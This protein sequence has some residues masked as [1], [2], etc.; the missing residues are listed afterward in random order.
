M[1]D[2]DLTAAREAVK[3]LRRVS[4]PNG[5]V[6]TELVQIVAQRFG[7]TERTVW[8]WLRNGVPQPRTCEKPGTH[9]QIAVAKENGNRKRAWQELRAE[10]AY[11]NGYRQFLRD[12]EMLSPVTHASIIG[13]VKAGITQGLYTKAHSEQRLDRVIFD[14]TEADI[15]LRRVYAGAEEMFRPWVTL[16]VDSATRMILAVVVT[17]GDGVRGDPPTESIVALMASAIRGSTAADGTF[18]GGVPRLVQ[19]DNAKAHLAEAMLN[20]YLEL[21]IAAHAIRPGSPWEDGKV[22][23]LMRTFKDEFLSALPGYTKALTDRYEREPWTPE[24][25]MP[26]EEFNERL[27]EW[28]DH[29]NF[30]RVHSALGTTPFE[31]WRDDTGEIQVV[32]PAMLRHGFLAETR[33]RKVSKNGLRF[34]NIDYTHPKLATYVGRKVELR[35]LPNDTTFI[36]VFIDGQHVCTAVPHA[37]LDMEQRRQIVRNRTNELKNVDHVVKTSRKRHAAAIRAGAA[38]D[39]PDRDPHSQRQP[40]RNSTNDD[41]LDLLDGLAP[42]EGTSP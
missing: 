14:H 32:E 20:G 40:V 11:T 22:E 13:G 38:G 37:R 24:D 8:N 33:P 36:E 39:R 29:Y 2:I 34:R 15:R 12:L 31:A 4:G 6:S 28:I 41:L 7:R 17:E 35:Y 26:I 18:I 23:R 27:Q 16:L 42:N 1:T 5:E 25:C 3:H 10:G 19:F 9:I 21:G 30:D